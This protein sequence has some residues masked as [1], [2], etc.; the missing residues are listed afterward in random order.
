MKRVWLIR[1][2]QHDWIGKALVGRKEG[3]GLNTTGHEQSRAIARFMEPVCV[4]AI[5]TSPQRR[6]LETAMP[7][8]ESKAL[9]IRV[10]AEIDEIDFGDW[11]GKSFAELEP[12]PDW[13][14]WNEARSVARIPGGETMQQVQQRV[15]RAI[16]TLASPEPVAFV[17]HGDVIRAAMTKFMGLSLDAIHSL[18][19][20]PGALVFIEVGGPSCARVE[21]HIPA[22][23]PAPAGV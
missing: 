20:E 3:I 11:T 13:R 10:S 6:A 7:L 14:H 22:R 12:N 16:E 5:Y 8:A 23:L 1:H 17:S 18:E 4:S 2:G 9:P 19:V 21:L 15:L